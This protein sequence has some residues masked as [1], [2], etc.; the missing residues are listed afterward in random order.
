MSSNTLGGSGLGE[1]TQ[2]TMNVF[3]KS[4]SWFS[5]LQTKMQCFGFFF[6]FWIGAVSFHITIFPRVPVFGVRATATKANEGEPLSAK[7]NM[8]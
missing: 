1:L 7:A 2:E 5:L 3:T 8:L 6:F 4:F